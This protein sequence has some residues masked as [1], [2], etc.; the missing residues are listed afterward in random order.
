[1]NGRS[2][3]ID[4]NI[5]LYLL[6]GNKTIANILDGSQLYISFITQPELLGCKGITSKEQ[7]IIKLFLNECIIIDIN[8]EIKKTTIQ[9]KQKHQIKL[10]DSTIAATAL[11]IEIPLLTADKGFKK[12][13]KLNL[14]LFEE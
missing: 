13:S 9:I 11:F 2:F 6:S 3:L 12:I 14:A 7:Q 8:E 1:M 10:P 5:A 4:T